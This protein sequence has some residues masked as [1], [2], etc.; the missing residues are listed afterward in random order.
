VLWR[1]SSFRSLARSQPFCTNVSLPSG[2]SSEIVA[3]RST[4]P[5]EALI[6]SCAAPAPNT[7]VLDRS[8]ADTN[9][10]EVPAGLWFQW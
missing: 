8:G 2:R 4:S 5:V 3:C 10:T 1:G 6:H 7:T 9:D